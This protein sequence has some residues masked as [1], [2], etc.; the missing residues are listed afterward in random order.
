[1]NINPAA[2]YADIFFSEK[3]TELMR[4]EL[5]LQPGGSQTDLM[6]NLISRLAA[7]ERDLGE[8]EAGTDAT[9][10]MFYEY[11]RRGVCT[12]G[13]PLLTNIAAG[14]QTL[15][16]C[17]AVPIKVD[18]LSTADFDLAEAYYNLNMGSG[19]DLTDSADPCGALLR[20]NQHAQRVET[21]GTC[22]RYVGNIAH[23]S[24]HHPSVIQFINVKRGREDVIHFNISVDVDDEFMQAVA[25]DS[26]VRMTDGTTRPSSEIWD[27]V[28]EAAWECGDPGIISLERYNSG[29]ALRES[30]PYVTTAPCAEVGLS[31]GETCVFGYINLAACL[32]PAPQLG[33][34][35]DLVGAAAEC[36]TRVLDDAVQSSLTRMPVPSSTSVM[37]GKRKIGIG[38]CGL[39]DTLLWLGL[40]Y[41]GPESER[42]L[43]DVLATVNFRS[44]QA[45]LR[46]AERRGS[47]LN[48]EMSEYRRGTGFLA[49]FG[50]IDTVVDQQAWD[51]L[52]S[53]VARHGLRNVMTTALPP[54]GRSAL[55]LGVNPSIE[56]YLSLHDGTDFVAPLR[57][58]RLTG[59]AGLE[60]S[61]GMVETSSL[62]HAAKSGPCSGSSIIRTASEITPEE[63]LRLLQLAAGLVDDGVSKTINLAQSAAPA[64][65]GQIFR[66]AWDAGLKAVSV[67]RL[68][69]RATRST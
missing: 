32:R 53:D 1:V 21:S 2:H 44:K 63:H 20:L 24:I 55:L 14:H 57:S 13:S 5:I 16:S 15:G 22:E 37:A 41:A 23:L 26:D 54:S 17:A 40:A 51:A 50:K 69:S 42:L 25:A 68:G 34:D 30:A 12:L 11:V 3:T 33:I 58:M 8:P 59:G 35:L 64:R 39:A 49:R 60:E 62:V 48:F 4:K 67:Y 65:V 6:A 10:A 28:V 7:A 27:A 18:Q 43:A 38:L 19:Y 52:A 31:P 46:L 56:P 29:N 66:Q 47:F 36:L 9:L 61:S 45:S